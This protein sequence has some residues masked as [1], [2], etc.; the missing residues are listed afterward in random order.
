MAPL[1]RGC[2]G[3][4]A[5]QTTS[6]SGSGLQR[7]LSRAICYF[8]PA[9]VEGWLDALKDR[10]Q[11]EQADLFAQLV[12]LTAAESRREAVA[13]VGKIAGDLAGPDRD[14]AVEYLAAIPLAVRRSLLADLTTGRVHVPNSL[15]SDQGRTLLGLLPTDVPPL[16]LGSEV[17][18]TSYRLEELLG[19]GGFGAVYKAIN[20]FEQH[21]PPRAIKFCLDPSMLATLHRERAILDR[22]MAVDG[23]T[24]SDRIVR[25]YGYA[26]D[27][28]PPFLVY[29][30]VPGGDLTNR[31][32]AVQRATGRGFSPADALALIRHVAEGLAFAH[33][34]GLVHR[35]LKP[36]NVLMNGN[37]VKLT[38]FGIG[39]V[40]ASHA[41]RGTS[42]GS[43]GLSLVTAADEARLFRGSGTPLYMSA[44]Q[45][46]GDQPDPRHDLYSLGVMWY[47]LLV[48]DVTRELHPG[49]PDEL[50]E[51]FQTPPEHIE[52]IQRCVGYFKK[53]P[54][55]ARELL[56]LLRLAVANPTEF[57]ALRS[58]DR[59]GGSRE[60]ALPDVVVTPSHAAPRPAPHAEAPVRQAEL[61]RLQAALLDQIDRDA[62]EEARATATALLRIKPGD[63]E[64]LEALAFIDQR[65]TA[66]LQELHPPCKHDGWVRSVAVSPD[67]NTALSGGDDA[68]VRLWDLATG[69]EVRRLTAHEGAVMSVAFAPGGRLAVSGSWDGT[70]R[71]WDLNNGMQVRRLAGTCKEVKCV[72]FGPD[73]RRVFAACSDHLIHRWDMETGR[74]IAPLEGHADLVQ[75][76]ALTPDGRHL[77]SGGDDGTVRVWDMAGGR[78]LHCFVGHTDTVACVCSA[79]DGASV[80]SASSDKT[81]RQWDRSG[82]REL[83]RLVGHANWV[84]SVVFGP[85][86]SWAVSGGGG[87]IVRGTFVDGADTT[88]RVWDLE[89]GHELYRFA[90]HQASV[91]AV[92][93]TPD[94]SRIIS[95]GLDETVRVLGLPG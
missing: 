31:L 94:G 58:A 74:E 83:R 35:D 7:S 46:R 64:A 86:G 80:L 8:G 17:P 76:L 25:L 4:L 71:V 3:T 93:V 51:E 88:V 33:G 41:L 69:R 77:I 59:A 16:P 57:L 10:P 14:A 19:I 13:A 23:A 50:W 85:D 43:A 65:G 1:L 92:A 91:T 39:S 47:Q 61:A 45:R 73:T 6:T 49:W 90:G 9:I 84:N 81:V 75:S 11:E 15:W 48:G 70:V 34:Q 78:E 60:F 68:T 18:G 22:L 27:V 87:E 37:N 55:N 26:L 30:Y 44:E 29:E 72:L 5:A 53:R 32:M 89:G 36:A 67:G 66:G 20:R 56:A 62:L 40:V 28:Q 52:L 79:P 95:A 54:A 42:I 21:Q 24:W 2:G 38:D 12:T 63:A 82:G